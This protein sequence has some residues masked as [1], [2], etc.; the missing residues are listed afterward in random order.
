VLLDAIQSRDKVK[1]AALLFDPIEKSE[2][3]I[4]NDQT[5]G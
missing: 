2:S 3:C 5:L 4:L 1:F